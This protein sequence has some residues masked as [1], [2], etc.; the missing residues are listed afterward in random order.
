MS[1]GKKKSKVVSPPSP[2]CG[3]HG[4]FWKLGYNSYNL[5]FLKVDD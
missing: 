2:F 4:L 3:G 5:E 1:K